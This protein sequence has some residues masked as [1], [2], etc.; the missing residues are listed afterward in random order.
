MRQRAAGEADRV[1]AVGRESPLGDRVGTAG[2]RLAGARARCPVSTVAAVSSIVT[3]STVVS[4]KPVAVSVKLGSARA[5]DLGLGIGGDGQWRRGD[6]QRAAGELDRVVAVGGERPLGDRVAAG[7]LAGRG[8]RL[9]R[10]SEPVS[11]VAAV[12]SIATPSTVA[13]TS[14]A[15]R[16]GQGWD[17]RRRRPWSGDWP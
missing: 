9:A 14:P 8:A 11:T 17:R 16:V 1:V 12:S 3:P 6:G 7:L 4:T 5:V 13:S 10:A 15:A 2:H